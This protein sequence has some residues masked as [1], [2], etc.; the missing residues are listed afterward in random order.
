MTLF[1]YLAIAYSLV[2]SFSATRLIS[3]LSYAAQ[4]DRRYWVHLVFTVGQLLATVLAFWNLWSF[5]D[6]TWTL[7][8]FSLTLAIPVSLHFLACALV[9]EQASGVESWRSYYFSARRRI[10]ISYIAVSVAIFLASRVVN[11]TPW[12][13]PIHL[14]Q[15]IGLSIG[16]TGLSFSDERVHFAL[17]VLVASMMSIAWFGVFVMPGAA[18]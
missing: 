18:S 15:F 17:A 7:H 5:R 4:A 6:A 9:P 3:G 13:N 11:E 12:L 16:V 14:T 2:L 1:E 8:I 10:F